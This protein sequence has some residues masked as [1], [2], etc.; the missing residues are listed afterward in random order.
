[1]TK[2]ENE[3][4]FSNQVGDEILWVNDHSFRNVTHDNAVEML[5]NTYVFNLVL[6]YVGKVPHSSTNA[7]KSY[8]LRTN[9]MVQV[10]K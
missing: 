10:N 5:K 2:N 3:I 6:R 4:F 1:M 7:L 8:D 9:N